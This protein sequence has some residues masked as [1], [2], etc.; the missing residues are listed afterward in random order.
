MDEGFVRA[1]TALLQ[2]LLDAFGPGR[3]ILFMFALPGIPLVFRFYGD[4][5]GE[6]G[7]KAALKTKDEAL[8]RVAAR[9]RHTRGT[10]RPRVL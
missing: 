3:I 4:W 7:W 9:E 5:R 6:R 10:A 1:I 2:L 8:Q